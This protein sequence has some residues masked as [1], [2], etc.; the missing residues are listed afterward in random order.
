MEVVN[1]QKCDIQTDNQRTI[2]IDSHKLE[3]VA[4]R[5]NRHTHLGPADRFFSYTSKICAPNLK[6][7]MCTCFM[8]EDFSLENLSSLVGAQ[9]KMT[10]REE[11]DETAETYTELPA[12]EKEVFAKCLLKFLGGVHSVQHLT[13]SSGFL[14]VLLQAP[15]TLYRQA[16]RLCNLVILKL[17][18]WFTRGCLRSIAYILKISPTL[19]ILK[20]QSKESNLADVEDDWEAEFSL[21]CMF[22][23]LEVVEIRE[24]EGCDNEKVNLFFQS[25]GDSLDNGRQVRRFKRNLRVLPTASSNIQMNFI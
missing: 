22:T 4:L 20:L 3:A 5:E 14:E 6:F 10:L 9:I 24:V 12:E 7:F 15:E 19:R 18:M 21:T 25:T 13:L 17:E 2:I 23:H 16:L 8:T 11:E 1:I